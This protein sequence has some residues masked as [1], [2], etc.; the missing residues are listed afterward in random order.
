MYVNYN[1]FWNMELQHF[2]IILLNE[3]TH[4]AWEKKIL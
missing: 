4:Y 1:D 3:M 2:K